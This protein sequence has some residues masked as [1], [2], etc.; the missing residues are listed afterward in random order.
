MTTT[1]EPES[2]EKLVGIILEV[3]DDITLQKDAERWIQELVAD[4]V[5]SAESDSVEGVVDPEGEENIRVFA[6]ALKDS[7]LDHGR[8]SVERGD[9]RAVLQWLCPLYPIC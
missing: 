3:L 8:D 5:R 9:V 4:G 2:T 1:R 6:A 7:A